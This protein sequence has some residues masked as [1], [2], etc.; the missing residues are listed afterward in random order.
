MAPPTQATISTATSKF[1]GG[2]LGLMSP[3]SINKSSNGV[4]S[5]TS[6]VKW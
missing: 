3:K 2:Y 6:P 4:T 5:P 1:S